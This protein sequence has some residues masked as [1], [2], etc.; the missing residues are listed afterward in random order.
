M[1][2]KEYEAL[3]LDK[4]AAYYT[5]IS[6]KPTLEEWEAALYIGRSLTAIRELRYKHEIS[7]VKKGA[8]IHYR[9]M[10]DLDKFLEDGVVKAV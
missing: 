9:R 3:T 2:Q 5:V 1:T 7:Y 8:R 4:Q 10:A 6:R